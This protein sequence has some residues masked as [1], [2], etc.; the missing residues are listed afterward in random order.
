VTH[1]FDDASKPCP[2][3]AGPNEAHIPADLRK[4]ARRHG[5]ADNYQNPYSPNERAWARYY[6]AFQHGSRIRFRLDRRAKARTLA[7]AA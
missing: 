5:F 3:G 6:N 7:L 4:R 1:N 2:C